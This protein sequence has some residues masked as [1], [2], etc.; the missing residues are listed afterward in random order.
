[1]KVFSV[2]C[3]LRGHPLLRFFKKFSY[4]SRR[5]RFTLCPK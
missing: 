2:Q 3:E 1:L 5:T 4:S